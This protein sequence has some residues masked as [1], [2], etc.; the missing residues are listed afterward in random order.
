[1]AS[2]KQ[3]L[4]SLAK[5]SDAASTEIWRKEKI[6][7]QIQSVRERIR[8]TEKMAERSKVTEVRSTKAIIFYVVNWGLNVMNE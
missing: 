1:M 3:S 6:S 7:Q 8:K 4:E 5:T 2:L